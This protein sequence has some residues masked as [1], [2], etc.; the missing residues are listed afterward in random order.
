MRASFTTN[1]H[2]FLSS[3]NDA[4]RLPEAVADNAQDE[5]DGNHRALFT[6]IAAPVSE[7]FRTRNGPARRN[8]PFR[9]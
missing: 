7:M 6:S 5:V 8:R 4:A 3:Q 9:P 1:P 2:P